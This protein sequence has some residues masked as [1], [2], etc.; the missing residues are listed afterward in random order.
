ML[1]S[2]QASRQSTEGGEGEIYKNDEEGLG[3]G[4]NALASVSLFSTSFFFHFAC[5]WSKM[6]GQDAF[7]CDDLRSVSSRS[8]LHVRRHKFFT[9]SFKLTQIKWLHSQLWQPIRQWNTGYCVRGNLRVR[10]VIQPKSLRKFNLQLLES[11]WSLL[12]SEKFLFHFSLFS[13]FLFFPVFFR[14]LSFPFLSSR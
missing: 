10:L 7:T 3:P 1:L 6:F 11:V 14:F 5:T 2:K 4:K 9:V 13:F 12:Y 8:N